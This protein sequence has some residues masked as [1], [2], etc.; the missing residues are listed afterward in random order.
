MVLSGEYLSCVHQRLAGR[1][2]RLE[3]GQRTTVTAQVTLPAAVA[4]ARAPLYSER[5]EV[6]AEAEGYPDSTVTIL[7]SADPIHL[8]VTVP[9]PEERLQLPYYP[10]RKDL[11]REVTSFNE[12]LARKLAEAATPEAIIQRLRTT[13]LNKAVEY[14]RA[15]ASA[16][17]LY[18]FTGERKYLDI[19]SA[20]LDALPK[21]W[22][23]RYAQWRQT[24]VRRIGDGIVTMNILSL[25]WNMFGT[26]RPPYLYGSSGGEVGGALSGLA[27]AFDLLTPAL[28]P[29]LRIR[30]IE[31]LL[32][33]AAIHSR[34]H[35]SAPGNMQCM[36]NQLALYGG[37][38]ARNWPLVAYDDEH[39]LL[40]NLE[41]AFDD[42]GLCVEG[43]YQ[44][45]TL[46]PVLWTEELL[47]GRGVNLYNRR[48]Y[49]CVHSRGAEAV[50]LVFRTPFVPFIDEKRFTPDAL[51]TGKKTDGFHLG[52]STLLRWNGLEVA[53]NR[54]T[55][56][57]RGSYDRCALAIR[58]PGTNEKDPLRSLGGGAYNHS[59]FGQSI[60]IVDEGLQNKVGAPEVLAVD[61]E[62]PVQYIMARSERHYPGSTITRTFVLIDRHVL[63]VDR[64]VNDKP[65][66]VD[67]YLAGAGAQVSLP[68]D[69]RNGSW[70]AKPDEPTTGHQYGGGVSAYRHAIT[71]ETWTEGNGRLTMLAGPRT[72]I[73]TF[74]PGPIRRFTDLMVRRRE[75]R[76]TD[77]VAMVS[78]DGPTIE[79]VPVR[80]AD[81][82]AADAVGVKASF[83]DKAAFCVLVSYEPNGTELRLG[84]WKTQQ[85]VATDYRE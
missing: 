35:Y 19:A 84:G 7:R 75:V 78:R 69:E 23:E 38:A 67:W 12:P 5:F 79:R 21:L 26:R 33:P 77:F 3:A 18:D 20:L 52:A 66:T 71:G 51:P 24:P 39:G 9:I 57:Y 81:N 4:A 36:S 17:Y 10:R 28:D 43:H 55:H 64:V 83:K 11:P 31:E 56:I 37:L 65:R 29:A 47:Y 73:M 60:I 41:W 59:S 30:F 72:E 6:R 70:T 46:C 34:N 48:L 2:H 44:F 32:L 15:L 16:A 74:S 76:Q 80:K 63:V 25:S 13:D 61:V 54:N 82:T 58:K 53:M 68:L 42:D 27:G 62:G 22:A 50:G 8:T 45:Y 85:R 14:Q 49:S 1:K 40:G